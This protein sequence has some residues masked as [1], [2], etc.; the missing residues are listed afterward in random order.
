HRPCTDFPVPSR[1]KLHSARQRSKIGPENRL[2]QGPQKG[3]LSPAF[4]R[5]LIEADWPAAASGR[6]LR[7]PRHSAGASLKRIRPL[8]LDRRRHRSLSPAFSRGLIEAV[9]C[10]PLFAAKKAPLLSPAFSR[11]L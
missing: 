8:G 2:A 6:G 5:G 11:G 10:P 7:Y 3:L 4:S 9:S 1:P